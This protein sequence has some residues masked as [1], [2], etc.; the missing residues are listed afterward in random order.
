MIVEYA[1]EVQHRLVELL[2]ALLD[3]EVTGLD[4]GVLVDGPQH[5]LVV[6]PFLRLVGHVLVPVLDFGLPLRC[7]LRLPIS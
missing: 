7:P 2:H 6:E 4:L 5:L 1:F 3:I